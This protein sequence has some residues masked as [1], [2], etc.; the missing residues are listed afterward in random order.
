MWWVRC[1]ACEREIPLGES[2]CLAC[3]SPVDGDAPAAPRVESRP[4]G[5]ADIESG[6]PESTGPESGAIEST[7]AIETASDSAAS[8]SRASESAPSDSASAEAARC[9]AHPDMPVAATCARCGT[10][11][12][13]RCTRDVLGTAAPLCPACT[14]VREAPP[15][16]IGGWLVVAAIHLVL[17]LLGL[18]GGTAVMLWASAQSDTLWLWVGTSAKDAAMR[19]APHVAYCA[20]SVWVAVQF[21]RKK[22]SAP[23]L[24]IAM[25]LANI[26]LAVVADADLR[27]PL[28]AAA[29]GVPYF[30]FSP[31]VK[32]TFVR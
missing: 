7:G 10:F 28:V 27:R 2:L 29:V 6:A 18:L 22:P 32:A 3:L 19:A 15:H 25:L 11:V 9:P 30:L 14:D 12:C 8:E 26:G 4:T 20:F 31:R 17:H 1:P 5:A 23:A 21:F 16:G 13:I 24:Y